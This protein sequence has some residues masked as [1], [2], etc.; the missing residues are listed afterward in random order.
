MPERS[1]GTITS[2]VATPGQPRGSN[3][4]AVIA[5]GIPALALVGSI[6]ALATWAATPLDVVTFVALPLTYGG[7]GAFLTVRVPGNPIG[8]M[9]LAATVGFALLIGSGAFVVGTYQGLPA[10]P[11]TTFAGLLANLTFIPSLVLVIVGI[12]LVFPDGRFLSARWRWVAVAAVITVGVAEATA[13]FGIPALSESGALPNP[14]YIPALVPIL[15]VVDTMT[16]VAAVPIFSLSLVSVVVRY[17]RSD[18]VG[19]HQI[20]WLAAASSVALVSFTLSFFALPMIGP[21]LEMIGNLSLTAIPLAIG[22]AIV[23]YR[24]YDIDRLISR[25]ISYG[26]VTVVLLAT[27]V[28]IV[29]VL[30]GPLGTIFGTQTVTVAISTLV[31]AG[32]FQPVRSRIHRAVDRRFDRARVDTERT[33]AAFSDRLRE[34]VDIDAVVGDLAATASGAVR[35]ERIDVWLRGPAVPS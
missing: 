30:Q 9:L 26:L 29:L 16:T 32:L 5:W 20:R 34:Q 18:D 4:R 12:P 23:R 1:A 28:T 13:L 10:S 17:R 31:I 25:G 15:E 6:A 24:L 21:V 19:R 3:L 2:V 11:A 27:Y 35:P 7:I 33:A 8:P 22:I 14:F